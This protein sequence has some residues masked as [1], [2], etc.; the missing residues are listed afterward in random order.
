MSKR[1]RPSILCDRCKEEI[2]PPPWPPHPDLKGAAPA[3]ET[4]PKNSTSGWP[5]TMRSSTFEAEKEN[6]YYYNMWELH[7]DAWLNWLD[8]DHAIELGGSSP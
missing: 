8:L 6:R 5:T 7:F 3:G 4:S 1:K 2:K